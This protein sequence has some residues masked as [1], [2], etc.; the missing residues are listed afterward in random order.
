M[1]KYIEMYLEDFD[2][3]KTELS[4]KM[5]I[6]PKKL[7]GILAGSTKI[8]GDDAIGLSKAFGTTTDLWVNLQYNNEIKKNE[9]ELNKEAEKVGYK[10]LVKEKILKESKDIVNKNGQ[11]TDFFGVSK[12]SNI[13]NLYHSTINYAFRTSDINK[14]TIVWLRRSEIAAK[15]IEVQEFEKRN[16][17]FDKVADSVLQTWAKKTSFGEKMASVKNVLFSANIALITSSYINGSLISGFVS[18]TNTNKKLVIHL[19]DKH[20]KSSNILFAILHELYHVKY[21]L[22][23]KGFEKYQDDKEKDIDG[24]VG[25]LILKTFKDTKDKPDFY[26]SC[27][28]W[29]IKEELKTKESRKEYQDYKNKQQ[30]VSFQ[31]GIN[32]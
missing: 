11:L 14:A 23:A 8:T 10:I 6:T 31:G 3:T 27:S 7:S 1:R 32:A 25:K 9:V 13:M 20:K 16:F 30:I 4:I 22:K 18:Y 12:M 17:D 29:K 15:K 28:L 24:E 5:G 26:T 19:S 21:H 2:M